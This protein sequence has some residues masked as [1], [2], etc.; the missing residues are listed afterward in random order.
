MNSNS[1]L[2]AEP[3]S[4]Y[5]QVLLANLKL[6][7]LT[8]AFI[9]QQTEAGVYHLPSAYQQIKASSLSIGK[10]LFGSYIAHADFP[11]ISVEET[12][13]GLLIQSKT[14]GLAGKLTEEESLVLHALLKKA[15]YRVFFD[16]LLRDKLLREKAKDY[17]L[18]GESSLDRFFELE[19]QEDELLLIPKL[20]S[21][22][23]VS[24]A[25]LKEWSSWLE[26]TAPDLGTA[27][28]AKTDQQFLLVIKQHKY[29][30]H[31]MIDLYQ[32]SLTKEGKVKQPLNVLNPLEQVWTLEGQQQ[33]KF[34]TAI[35]KF[36]H[37]VEAK[38]SNQDLEALK[39]ILA[40]PFDYPFYFH[41]AARS[42]KIN[43]TSI[44][45]VQVKMLPKTIKL[46]IRKKAP[47]YELVGTIDIEGATYAMNG[48]E[49]R[50]TYFLLANNTLYLVDSVQVLGLIRLFKYTNDHLLIH[51]AKYP[52]FR[53]QVLAKLEDR[54]SLQYEYV[55]EAGQQQLEQL[56]TAVEKQIYL[57]DFGNFVMMTPVVR[58]GEAEV[59]VR[60]KKQIHWGD[61]D[62]EVYLVKRDEQLENNFVSLLIR[63]HPFFEEQID[64][65]LEYLYLHRKR[66]LDEEWFLNAFDTWFEEGISIFGF[67]ELEGSRY[68]PYKGKVTIRIL[69]G[70]NWFNVK[71]KV[72]FGRSKA[73]LKQ[74]STAIHDKRKFVRLDDGTLGIIPEEWIDKFIRY[75]SIGELLDEETI[76]IAK[77]NFTAIEELFDEEQLD[78]SVKKE[79]VL[80]KERLAHVDRIE[81]VAA[82]ERLQG[83]LRSYQEQG[84]AW[85]NFLDDMGFGGCLAD[86]MGL[87]KSI[88]II[89]FL[90]HLREKQGKRTHL[91]IV[92]TTLMFHW[93]Q[94][95]AKFA[96]TLSVRSHHA[97]GRSKD[98]SAF[99][100]VDI[101]LTTYGTMVSDIK[102]LK[103]K[104][105]DYVFLDESQYIKNPESQRYKAARLLV[106]RNRMV[107]SG[108][109]L[110]NNVFDLFGQLSFINPGILGNKKYFKDVYL[111]PIDQFHDQKRLKMLRE[112]VKPFILRRTKREVEL[113]L[114]EKTEVLLSCEMGAVQKK[115][116]KA[117]ER[118][119]REYI[120]ATTNE[121]LKRSSV[122]VLRGLTLLRQICDSPVLL[123]EGRLPGDES[124]K[125]DTLMEQ[126]TEKAP[127]H[128]ILVFSQFVSML[129]LIRKELDKKSI[130]YA[131]LTGSTRNRS[132]VVTSFQE[133]EEKRVFLISLKAGGTGLN[134]TAA[135]YVYMVDPW[136]NPAVEN[137]AIDRVHRIGQQKHVVAVR[138]VCADTVEEKMMKLQDKKRMLFDELIAADSSFFQKLSKDDLLALLG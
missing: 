82:P 111:L 27:D 102:L 86:D 21:L 137:Q 104:K 133:E 91:L 1:A 14:D 135:D 33:V 120:S 58:Y 98:L 125:L 121:E 19:Y 109:P 8:E 132:Q 90:L 112:K 10:G 56:G 115:I 47:F 64:N 25:R 79:L 67:N 16:D 46:G 57:A 26:P 23:P 138:L 68:N 113:E 12:A 127:Q 123:G 101:V 70:F 134:L 50:F 15:S 94:E 7:Q 45:P 128:K 119:F 99:D 76:G 39:A 48:L 43:P 83:T 107:I 42:E 131:Y 129:D 40:N 5:H 51:E 69:S 17:G 29:Y 81:E 22:L 53:K 24:D 130:A 93:Q 52:D 61:T 114:P 44:V 55:K 71:A 97:G 75:F 20:S 80:Y 37:P 106:A 9:F 35:H 54:I 92:P 63:Q 18:E 77:S 89:A 96:P 6:S 122:H 117:Y 30:H 103:E 4:E 36:Q 38:P 78:A 3:S 13:K 65:E 126:I 105:F 88:Q 118:E 49:L 85:L 116:Y 100:E 108:T 2:L 34:F 32:A 31:L 87:G 74:L 28:A 11:E 59:A 62:G 72:F 60:S 124:A 73:S 95:V 136:W 41:D 84:L 110:E 66:F